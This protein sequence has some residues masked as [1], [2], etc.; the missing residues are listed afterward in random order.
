MRIIQEDRKHKS[1]AW[2]GESRPWWASLSRMPIC[3]KRVVD[4]GSDDAATEVTCGSCLR[5]L[6]ARGLDSKTEG[7]NG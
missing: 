2:D 6:A 7:V 1:H 4:T 5:L 3:G